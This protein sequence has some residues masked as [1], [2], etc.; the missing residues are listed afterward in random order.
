MKEITEEL[1]SFQTIPDNKEEIGECLDYIEDYFSDTG[2][3]VKVFENGE[4]RSLF[5]SSDIEDCEPKI[6]LHGHIDVVEA[7]EEMFQARKEDGKLYGRG[8]ADMKAGVSCLMKLMKDLE[9]E[10]TSL[11]ITSDEEVGGFNGTGYMVNEEGLRPSFVISAEPNEKGSFPCIINRHKGVYQVR[12]KASGESCH[13]SQ[14]GKGVNAIDKLIQEYQELKSVFA[15]EEVTSTINLGKINGGDSLNQVPGSAELEVDI[16]YDQSLTPE[17]IESYLEDLDVDFEVIA[18]APM[19]Q[20]SRNNEHVEEL[21]SCDDRDRLVFAKQDFAS[22]ARFFTEK[23]IPAV[24]FG[25]EGEEIHGEGE[26]VD[27]N[28]IEQL[29]TVLDDFISSER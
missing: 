23:G 28:S 8:T 22:D 26:N 10:N 12:L 19:M 3:E 2:L 4:V 16:R 13:A 1:V 24:L 7:S 25:P 29:Y 6:L 20:T 15:N 21:A 14:P 27:I 17:E 5:I 18:E 11:L 9:P